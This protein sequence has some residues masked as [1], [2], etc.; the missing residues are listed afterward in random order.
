[1]SSQVPNHASPVNTQVTDRSRLV[2]ETAERKVVDALAQL[3]SPWQVFSTVEWRVQ[4]PHG[5][6]IGEADVVVFHPHL[7]VVVIEIKGG[8]VR[9]V[10]GEWLYA[11]GRSMGNGPMAQ[12]RRNRYALTDKLKIRLREELP[13][14]TFTHAIWLPDVHWTGP[15]PSADFPSRHFLLD[16]D[17]LAQ[18]EA[19]LTRLF[20]DAQPTPQRWTK[21]QAQV[22][23]D[24]LA[25]DCQ[26]LEP[27]AVQVERAS[28]EMHQATEAQLRVLRLLATQQRLLVCGGA[29]TGKTLLA[30]TLARAHAAQ[31]RTVLVTCF[32]RH[33]A[34]FLKA[35]FQGTE[36][37]VVGHFHELARLW[38]EE[39]GLRFDVPAN[40]ADLTHFFRHVVPERVLEA[41]ESMGQRFDTLVV[42]EAAD[43]EPTWWIAL[44]AMG[45]PSHSHYCFYDLGQRIYGTDQDWQPPFNLPPIALSENLRNSRPI[46]EWAAQRGRT[47]MPETFRVLDGPNP[48][49][50]E[51]PSHEDMGP[52]LRRLLRECTVT[53]RLGLEQVVVL[54]PY[55]HD[56]PRSTWASVLEGT[57]WST[58]LSL[59]QPGCL[60]VG[61]LQGFKGLESD[62]IILMG[63]D[64]RA[65]SHPQWLYVGATRARMV[66]YVVR[67]PN[68]NW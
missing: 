39:A 9:V 55:R 61:T 24:L 31:G 26:A 3:P 44:E 14:L 28:K 7:G 30:C 68:I 54:S 2:G 50:T 64:E 8:A 66:L 27:L 62:A 63:I 18:P 65:A 23:K 34:A 41:A 20:K 60:R 59:K 1:M 21:P 52:V 45:K 6:Q 4:L 10:N 37:V 51:V 33:L 35:H 43:F 16:R 47:P 36:G 57:T 49:I 25:P 19:A 46:G 67:T 56:N 53:H 12:A 13:S 40:P 29:G 22:L 58:D 32:N 5:E 42:D 17:A 48:H 11:S 15:L 38:I